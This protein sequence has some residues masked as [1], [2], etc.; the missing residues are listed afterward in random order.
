MIDTSFKYQ[1][2]PTSTHTTFLQ[3]S[4]AILLKD[5]HAG[6]GATV[7]VTLSYRFI[8]GFTSVDYAPGM[9][10]VFSPLG[11]LGAIIPTFWWNPGLDWSWEWRKSAMGGTGKLA[12]EQQGV[13]YRLWYL[14]SYDPY[15]GNTFTLLFAGPRQNRRHLPPSDFSPFTRGN[16]R[17]P[18]AA[19]LTR[20]LTEEVTVKVAR[21]AEKK[22]RLQERRAYDRHAHRHNPHFT[23]PEE[24]CPPDGLG[25][26]TCLGRK[27]S[28]TE[29]MYFL[30]LLL[31]DWKLDITLLERET[32]REDEQR[33][34]GA[35]DRL[36]STN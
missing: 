12:L 6:L 22:P 35:S 11:L 14:E 5:A 28:H 26:H 10:P 30:A 34:S 36:T 19:F 2:G 7:F 1:S 25:P 4:T 17:L 9:R 8:A 33:V 21:P 13:V 18:A 31:R 16:N 3:T 15:P 27:F 23:E 32:R 29:A 20:E 24:Y